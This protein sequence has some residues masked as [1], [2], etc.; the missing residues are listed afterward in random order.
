MEAV[1]GTSTEGREGGQSPRKE[2]HHQKQRGSWQCSGL[3]GKSPI[4][5]AGKTSCKPQPALAAFPRQSQCSS[6][7]L[8]SK[9]LQAVATGKMSRYSHKI[10]PI[11]HACCSLIAPRVDR[12]FH[13]DQSN[14]LEWQDMEHQNP[15]C[16]ESTPVHVPLLSKMSLRPEAA[17]NA[18][19]AKSAWVFLGAHSRSH[20]SHLKQ[21]F[22]CTKLERREVFF[23][24]P[25]GKNRHVAKTSTRWPIRAEEEEKSREE[26]KQKTTEGEH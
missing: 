4:C 18:S 12:S 6:R 7:L 5:S 19:S 3:A 8:A 21:M 14:A 10:K 9:T 16:T 23:L 26:S 1:F 25:K 11:C 13:L 17:Q 22:K 20:F 15:A 2:E 24:S